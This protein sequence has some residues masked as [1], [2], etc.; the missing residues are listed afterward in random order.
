MLAEHLLVRLATVGTGVL[1]T[2]D[3]LPASYPSHVCGLDIGHR[4]RCDP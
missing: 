2:M 3:R 4:V 1:Q